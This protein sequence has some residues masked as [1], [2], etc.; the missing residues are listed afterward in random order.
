MRKLVLLGT[1][2]FMLLFT[3]VGFADYIANIQMPP[4]LSLCN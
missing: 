2:L 1:A 4:S 3:G